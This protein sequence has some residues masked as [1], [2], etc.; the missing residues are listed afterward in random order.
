MA[1][2]H[3]KKCSPSPTIREEQSEAVR[4]HHRKAIDQTDEKKNAGQD[5]K[6]THPLHINGGNVNYYNL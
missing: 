5:V 1:N 4:F 6:R 2:R 3:V